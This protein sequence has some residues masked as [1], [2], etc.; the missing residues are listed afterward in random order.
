MT[1][2]PKK[3]FRFFIIDTKSLADRKSPVLSTNLFRVISQKGSQVI[4]KQLH[5]NLL[6]IYFVQLRFQILNIEISQFILTKTG[7]YEISTMHQSFL[8]PN[9][10]LDPSRRASTNL[11]PPF[12]PPRG[13]PH[14]A[15]YE[16]M[17]G[18]YQQRITIRDCEMFFL[19]QC[20]S[21]YLR[22]KL[23][24]FSVLD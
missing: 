9:S 4:C 14:Q 19:G 11:Q 12:A 18:S 10:P 15:A 20:P 17:K 23:S 21:S 5:L 24:C 22:I 13:S 1:D 16:L 8:V 2:L 3:Q 7:E 6:F